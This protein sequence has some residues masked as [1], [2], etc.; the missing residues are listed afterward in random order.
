MHI[1]LDSL[2][3][4]PDLRDQ[5][6]AALIQDKSG[7]T[8]ARLLIEA[9]RSVSLVARAQAAAELRQ[10]FP[11]DRVVWAETD[12]LLYSLVPNWHWNIVHDHGRNTAYRRAIE[13]SVKPGM[14]V[15]EIGAGTGLLAMMAAR[16]GAAHVY[17]IEGNPIM[18]K[19]ARECVARNGLADRVTVLHRHSS[20]VKIG[21][22]LPRLA[23]LLI[24]EILSADLLDEGVLPSIAHARRELLTPDAL[25][26][27]ERL[28]IE[29]ALS[30]DL[31]KF[32]PD[33]AQVMGF[34][35]SPL[36]QIEAGAPIIEGQ[37]GG[38]RLSTPQDLLSFDLLEDKLAME[39]GREMTLT[40]TNAGTA[41]G[42]EQW[43]GLR[44]PCGTVLSSDDPGSSWGNKFHPFG[45]TLDIAAGDDVRIEIV[46]STELLAIS[47]ASAPS[48][49]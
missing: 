49:P 17:T 1:D 47:L 36:H 18:A 5:A 4:P 34:D 32:G 42:I 19:I 40:A 45:T 38:S 29:G 9:P 35:L 23:D 7:R 11:R 37:A 21:E 39:S 16:A 14:L 48:G 41:A 13:A 26:L 24:H 25:L 28:W 12:P 33:R 10:L 44:F 8:L 43:I 20:A 27:P 2:N 22:D 30:G 31:T 15:L 6:D 46:H 3:F